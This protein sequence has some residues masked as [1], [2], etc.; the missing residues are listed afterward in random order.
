[1]VQDPQLAEVFPEPPL[2]AYKRPKNIR[3]KAIRSKVPPLPTARPKRELP[4][5][6][7]CRGCPICPFVKTGKTIKATAS[8]YIAEISKQLDCKSRNIIY[9]ITCKK[10]KMQ[11]IGETDRSL[12]DRFS[13]HKGYVANHRLHKATGHHFN[14][15]GHKISDMEVSIVEKIFNTDGQFRKTREKLMIRNFN[16]KYR[17]MNR[18]T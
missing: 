17:G 6:K 2:T 11:Y 3:D 12:Q 7:T 10:C 1:M 16:T 5:M 9:C 8:K 18:K 13:E 14:L 4:G 15:P